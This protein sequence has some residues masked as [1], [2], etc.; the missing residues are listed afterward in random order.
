MPNQLC[1]IT[2]NLPPV[3]TAAPPQN[4]DVH[5][6][7]NAVTARAKSWS[8]P[9]RPKINQSGPTG[10]IVKTMTSYMSLALLLCAVWCWANSV[11]EYRLPHSTVPLSI[12]TTLRHLQLQ[13]NKNGT[14]VTF[15][16]LR[17]YEMLVYFLHMLRTA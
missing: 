17:L 11:T 7:K 8:D 3:T 10:R 6:Q 1:D 5:G 15:T 9:A 16:H 4:R 12:C 2:R 14:F 13:D